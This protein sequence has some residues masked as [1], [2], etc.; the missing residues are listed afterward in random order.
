MTVKVN[1]N[2]IQKLGAR[3]PQDSDAVAR[4]CSV[5]KLFLEI[6]QNP[7]ENTLARVSFLIKLRT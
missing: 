6:P 7:Q 2:Y 4:R 1:L 3:Y 5:K